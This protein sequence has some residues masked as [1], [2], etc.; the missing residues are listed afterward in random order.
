[1][2]KYL[3]WDFDGTLAYRD[4]M[5]SSTIY[6]LLIEN[7]F[8]DF[9]VDDIKPHLQSGFPWHSPEM[10]HEEFFDGKKWWEYMNEHFTEILRKLGIQ[11][12]AAVRIS[13]CIR[14]RYLDINKWHV[15][16]DTVYCLKRALDKGYSNIILSNHVPELEDLV[17]NL[18]IGDYFIKIY[19]SANIGYE[20]PNEKIFEKVLM[21]LNDIE[22]I[23][24]IGDSY[25]ADIQGAKEAGIDAILVRKSNNFN[26][27]K[28]FASLIELVDFL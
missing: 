25:I 11:G 26:Y 28:Y 21:N 6:E 14:E 1:M 17:K 10:S 16:D 12:D 13:N 15:Y 20:K 24:M 5:W 27:D 18:N 2:A 3:L 4:G 22:S 23:T 19:S 8:Y 9:K 7:G